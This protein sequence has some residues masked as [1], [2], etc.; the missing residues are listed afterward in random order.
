[1]RAF[2]IQVC[3]LLCGSVR[4][5]AACQSRTDF[6]VLFVYC[7]CTDCTKLLWQCT[8][9]GERILSS[10]NLNSVTVSII[11]PL[12]LEVR[13]TN[14]PQK[15]NNHSWSFG[16]TKSAASGRSLP[17]YAVML[18]TLLVLTGPSMLCPV[19]DV[20]QYKTVSDIVL[21]QH[22]VVSCRY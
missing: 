13:P 4:A 7:C 8:S 19:Y 2:M 18:F 14:Y 16:F 21:A 15:E 11:S 5:G 12:S 3:Q 20:I 9:T 22:T 17:V 10:I 6:R 1:M